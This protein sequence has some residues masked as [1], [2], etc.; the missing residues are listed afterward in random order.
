MRNISLTVAY[1]GTNYHGWQCQPNVVTIQETLKVAVERI[2]NHEVNIIGGARTDAGVHA[3]GQVVNFTTSKEIAL[4]NLN[5][6]LNS[7]LPDDIRIVDARNA[8]PDFHAR[9][10][11]KSKVYIYSIL[12]QEHN[13]PFL[14]RYVLHHP[15]RLNVP[16]MKE[17]ASLVVGEHDF[18]AFKKKDELYKNPVREVTR[19]NVGSRGTIVYV[20]IEAA[21]FL[22]YMVRN[23]VGTL[24][25]VGQ[26]K[27]DRDG[28]Q[29]ILESKEREKAGPTAPPQGLFLRRIKY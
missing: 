2:L 27:I 25:L 23:I 24:L 19:A 17:A 3:M 18:S 21:G 20:V 15:Y 14:Q 7:M 12:N 26:G 6:G 11:A 13:S 16:S 10:S 9:Y 1:D 5:K 28:F 29:D 22:R 8:D 4:T